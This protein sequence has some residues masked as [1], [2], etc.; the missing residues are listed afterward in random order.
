MEEIQIKHILRKLKNNVP[1][2]ATTDE[3][4]LSE[5]NYDLGSLFQ[6]RCM[7]ETVTLA[8]ASVAL[9]N[10][11]PAGALVLYARRHNVGTVT[12]TTAVKLGIG[13]SGTPS[14]YLLSD[15]TMTDGAGDTLDAPP[16]PASP[17][18]AATQLLLSACATGGTQ[19]G[20]GAGIVKVAIFYIV[21]GA[22]V[23]SAPTGSEY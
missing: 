1:L 17:L 19:A 3:R 12:L 14:K 4:I 11:L 6:L 22:I 20:T 23:V 5:Y 2:A 10:N 15:T 18:A 7:V 13:V 21:V 8:G 9:T 16:V